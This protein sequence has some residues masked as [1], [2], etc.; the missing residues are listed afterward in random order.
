MNKNN[1]RSQQIPQMNQLPNLGGRLSLSSSPEY[2]G[3]LPSSR[4]ATESGIVSSSIETENK[5]NQPESFEMLN[6]TFP[7]DLLQN[8]LQL[9]SN[10]SSEDDD[11]DEEEDDDDDGD[12]EEEDDDDD[13]DDDDDSD[14][15]DV[16]QN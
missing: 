15:S 5:N 6:E 8:D 13:D 2:P 4:T 7:S 11:D 14:D 10:S 16:G 3:R 9:S 12:D 1:T